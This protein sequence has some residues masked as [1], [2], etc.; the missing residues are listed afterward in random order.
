MK[1]AMDS[2]GKRILPVKHGRGICPVCESTV[3]A[4]CGNKRAHH[5]AHESLVSCAYTEYEHTH[6]T[7]WHINWKNHFP[8]NWQE[9]ILRDAEGEKHISDVRTPDGLTIEFQHSPISEEERISR[10]KFYSSVGRMIWVVD[11]TKNKHDWNRWYDNRLLRNPVPNL[12]DGVSTSTNTKK[13]LPCEWLHCDVPIFF[14]F[15]GTESPDETMEEKRELICVLCN[16]DK[17]KHLFIP[18]KHELFIALCQSGKLFLW[19][20]SHLPTPQIQASPS[21]THTPLSSIKINLPSIPRSR[22][23]P[24]RDRQLEKMLGLTSP[25][26]RYKKRNKRQSTSK[27]KQYR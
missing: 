10:E 12:P 8:V 15:L 1:F 3:I 19:M 4:R 14:D 27:K 11:G 16:K 23:Q 2:E 26:P 7:P 6:E 25:R 20:K 18:I 5:W 9:I 17:T 21:D 22:I 13:M 24:Y